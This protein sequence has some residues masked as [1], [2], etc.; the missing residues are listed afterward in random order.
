MQS[1]ELANYREL[2]LSN[3]YRL[4]V[5][6]CVSKTSKG[7]LIHDVYGY[8]L[9]NTVMIGLSTP[10]KEVIPLFETMDVT[11]VS[12]FI[13]YSRNT[14][15]RWYHYSISAKHYGQD[16]DK[17]DDY[18]ESKFA[19]YYYVKSV[20]PDDSD[21]YYTVVNINTFPMEIRH[22]IDEII[23]HRRGRSRV[24]IDVESLLFHVLTT[25]NYSDIINM[26]TALCGVVDMKKYTSCSNSMGNQQVKVVYIILRLMQ[27]I[28]LAIKQWQSLIIASKCGKHVESTVIDDPNVPG[29][30]VDSKPFYGK[31]MLVSFYHN[32]SHYLRFDINRYKPLVNS[33]RN[34]M[35]FAVDASA[36]KLVSQ[37]DDID[38]V[39]ATKLQNVV[40]D[41]NCILGEMC[42]IVDI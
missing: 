40:K 6:C 36:A 1:I 32:K 14:H 5:K 27:Q 8:F 11:I 30:K 31:N 4:T 3:P 33:I 16:F 17:V 9:I 25:D 24:I 18:T 22:L 10:F 19:T 12:S 38:K 2:I 37:L 23:R 29:N 28:L 34:A 39:A 35:S 42:K 20:F 21:V 41:L 15:R 13:G 7:Q 26:L